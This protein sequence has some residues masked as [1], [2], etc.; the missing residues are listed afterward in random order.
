MNSPN[1]SLAISDAELRNWQSSV[2]FFFGDNHPND[3]PEGD[4]VTIY[5]IVLIYTTSKHRNMSY[6]C[7]RTLA[8]S[9][10]E[11]P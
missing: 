10:C 1:S 9:S 5:F 3:N 4:H 8:A 7:W 11:F 6:Y 2:F